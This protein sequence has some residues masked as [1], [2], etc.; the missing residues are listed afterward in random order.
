MR[1]RRTGRMEMTTTHRRLRSSPPARFPIAGRRGRDPTAARVRSRPA[2]RPAGRVRRSGT[3]WLAGP[4]PA[5]LAIS[6][7]S[8]LLPVQV[9]DRATG[10]E[11]LP[12]GEFGFVLGQFGAPGPCCL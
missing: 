8:D 6:V 1:V 3:R 4:S 5:K 7:V 10:S 12:A 9:A 11:Y 2:T